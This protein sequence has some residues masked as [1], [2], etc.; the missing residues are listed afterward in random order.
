MNYQPI[1]YT[2]IAVVVGGMVATAWFAKRYVRSVADFL[3][4]NRMAGKYLLTVAAGGT[5]SIGM[6]ASWQMLNNAGLST[7]WWGM[8]G[9]PVG[10]V[11]A[12]TGF[13]IFR[14]RETRALTLA[15]FLEMRY[16][17]KFRFF[18]GGLSWLSGI[19]N[20]GVFPAVTAR[21]IIAIIG[22]PATFTLWGLS[23]DTYPSVMAGYLVIA[24][25]IACGGG[26]ISIMISDFYQ[27]FL[28]K[29]GLIVVSL[30][31]YFKF[32]WHNIEAGLLNAPAG[33]SMVNPFQT[34]AID[35]FN[36]WYFLIG[37]FG[38]VFN[39]RSWQGNSGYNSAARTPHD[40]QMAGILGSWRNLS[41][42]LLTLLPPLVAYAVF[43]NLCFQT[44][45]VEARQ[46]LDAITDPQVR[47]QMVTPTVLRLL[48]PPGMIG[49]LAALIISGS[50]SID[51]T[52]T[53]SWGTIF[54]QDVV[55]PLKKK[56]FRPATHLLLLRCSIIGVALF[57]FFFSLYF[58][59]Q[60]HIFM[61]FA[62]TGII[63]LGG[64]GVVIIGGLYTR[65]GT[66]AGAYSAM[67]AG[68]VLGFGGMLLQQ[69]W[70]PWLCPLL[71]RL[72]PASPYLLA[73]QEKFP[74]NGQVLYFIAMMTATVVYVTVSLLNRRP[75]FN[76]QK[77]LHRGVY[78]ENA[79]SI[80]VSAEQEPQTLPGRI[81]RKLGITPRFSG[82]E[83]LVFWATL[84]WSL[85]WWGIFLAGTLYNLFIQEFSDRFW[86]GFWWCKIWLSMILG[87][88]TAVWILCG[89]VRDACT[90][91]RE[92]VKEKQDA[93]DDGFVTPEKDKSTPKETA[94]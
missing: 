77:M 70:T 5:G 20:Y 49:F 53:H 19:L 44:L 43:H 67:A 59:F 33:H 61:F 76:L 68:T 85:G 57:G 1:D 34:D 66:T 62:L 28:C 86:C 90:M 63:Y 74:I 72:V 80:A 27:E 7:Q 83:H 13:I 25:Y 31:L 11:L 41:T 84:I 82:F 30:Y 48:L 91:F 14:F 52:Y 35:D 15:Q 58:P 87:L 88:I 32:G 78:A 64:A 75:P 6:I 38:G 92:L 51:D 79:D 8:V 69:I 89:G 29:I 42:I 21:A 55:M 46:A 94:K 36:I 40:A 26:L 16:S 71:L 24:L 93:N 4:A 65:W 18:A 37:V 10:L 73:H 9:E 2:M 47:N 50:I 45:A 17:R 12:L 54:I 3:A 23:F 56:A 39:S 81:G 22:L 60:D